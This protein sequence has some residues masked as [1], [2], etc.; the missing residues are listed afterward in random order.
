MLRRCVSSPTTTSTWTPSSDVPDWSWSMPLPYKTLSSGANIYWGQL[1][2]FKQYP[3]N[4]NDWLNK[5]EIERESRKFIIQ[6]LFRREQMKMQLVS[7]GQAVKEKDFFCKSEFDT[8]EATVRQNFDPRSEAN[9]EVW[10]PILFGILF[11]R[12][13]FNILFWLFCWGRSDLLHRPTGRG[14]F[15]T[16][17]WQYQDYDLDKGDSG[18]M[19]LIYFIYN[20]GDNSF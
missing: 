16:G 7:T 17:L 20:K 6:C 2:C 12:L 15:Q 1:Y 11:Q 5:C 4:W 8:F 13:L 18:P 3:S 14:R 9:P 19:R 10:E